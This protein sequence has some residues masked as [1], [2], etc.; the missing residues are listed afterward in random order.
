MGNNASVTHLDWD[1]QRER[2]SAYLDSELAATERAA[3][4]AHLADCEQCQRELAALRQMRDVLR[5]LPTPALPRAFTL[6]VSPA[7]SERR[8]MPAWSRPAQALGGLAAMVGLGLLIGTTAPH[9]STFST[10]M[11]G[12]STASQPIAPGAGAASVAPSP[13]GAN[14]SSVRTPAPAPTVEKTPSYAPTV[15]PSQSPPFPVAPVTGGTLLVGGAAA[16][17]AGSLA[18]RRARRLP[19]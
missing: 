2:L 11:G 8:A 13:T 1:D 14:Q 15:T 6:P 12:A 3:V 18:R 7:P 10:A 5:A 17:T 19:V 4:E 9:P 16:W